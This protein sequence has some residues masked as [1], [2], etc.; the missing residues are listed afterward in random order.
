MGRYD[1][2]EYAAT[3]NSYSG[4][5]R[6]TLP[7]QL[8]ARVRQVELDLH[9]NGYVD[10]QGYR[11]GHIWPGN[12]VDHSA[13]NPAGLLLQD[14]L[15]VINAWSSANAGHGPITVVFDVKDDLL[16][17]DDGG[18][19]EDF[20]LTLEAGFPGK[21]FTRDDYGLGPWPK[22]SALKDKVVCVISGDRGTRASY[23]WTR[24]SEPTIAGNANGD[25]VL[26][27]LSTAGDLRCWTGKVDVAPGGMRWTR[28]MTYK[29][30]TGLSQ[31]AIALSDDGWVVAVHAI[32]A[33]PTFPAGVVEGCVGHLQEDGRILWFTSKRYDFGS[34]PSL[35]IE[36]DQVRAICGALTGGGRVLCR[37]LLDRKKRAVQWGKSRSTP[38]PPF[39]RDQG[40]SLGRVVQCAPGPAAVIQASVEQGAMQPVRYRQVAFVEEQKGDDAGLLVDP[41]FFAADAGDQALIVAARGAGKVVRAWGFSPGQETTPP[42]N[43]PATDDPYAGGYAPHVTGPKVVA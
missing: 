23:R 26:A 31:P 5:S 17:N 19:L 33:T 30:G 40:T 22:V 6:G 21:L 24:G 36:G 15:A 28:R 14:W 10:H 32:A 38:K 2:H 39:P 25:V 16:D 3:H 37:G 13:G 18:D 29:W 41:L 12:E 7:S 1:E 27:Y 34:A 4:G 20:N 42:A 9:D 43:M 8:T 35:E 11:V